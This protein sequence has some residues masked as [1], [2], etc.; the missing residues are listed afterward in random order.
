MGNG[1]T[2]LTQLVYLEL[3]LFTEGLSDA[4]RSGNARLRIAKRRKHCVCG[5]N[6]GNLS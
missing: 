2:L 3:N 1:L 4:L 6:F 5:G